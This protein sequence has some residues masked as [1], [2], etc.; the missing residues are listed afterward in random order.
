[1]LL[2][3]NILPYQTC[4][5]IRRIYAL[6]GGSGGETKE[7]DCLHTNCDK[8]LQFVNKNINILRL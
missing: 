7:I 6:I 1:M 3:M 8:L 4:I 5:P 2:H